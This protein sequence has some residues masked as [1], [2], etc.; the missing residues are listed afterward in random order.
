MT[1]PLAERLGEEEERTLL[2]PTRQ[3]FRWTDDNDDDDDDDDDNDD[4]DDADDADDDN[5][6]DDDDEDDNAAIATNW[7]HQS[8]LPAQHLVW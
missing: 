1:C 5:D 8:Q 2:Q 7:A 4:D 6:N 3:T